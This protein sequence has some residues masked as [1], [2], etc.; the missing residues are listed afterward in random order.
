MQQYITLRFEEYLNNKDNFDYTP[1]LIHA[2]LSIN[3]LLYNEE[4]EEF[5]GII[6]F[7]DMQIGDL[8]FEYIYLLDDCGIDFTKKVIKLRQEVDIKAKLKRYLFS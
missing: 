2:D 1:K 4:N 3:H 7:G 8:D 6:D 5:I